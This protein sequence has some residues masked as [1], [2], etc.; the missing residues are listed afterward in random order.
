MTV[1]LGG[2]HPGLEARSNNALA[3]LN[4]YHHTEVINFLWLLADA[5]RTEKAP[6]NKSIKNDLTAY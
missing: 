5:P 6:C 4:R 3:S 1:N 2:N